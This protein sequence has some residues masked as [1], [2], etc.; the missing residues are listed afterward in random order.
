MQ[1]FHSLTDC[2]L[3]SSWVSI[4]SFDGVHLGHQALIK[5]LVL[6]AQENHSSATII[7]FYPHPAVILRKQETP[8]YLT[9]PD[10]RALLLAKFDVE[11]VITLP[12]DNNMAS[13]SA[14]EFIQ[15]LSK[16][17]N[18][19]K[20]LVGSDFALGKNRLGNVNFLREIG[21]KLGFQVEIIPPILVNNEKVSSS[22]IRSLLTQGEIDHASQM[23]G[24][25]YSIRGSVAHGD[26]RGKKLGIPTANL[27]IWSEQ[28]IPAWG[29]Y[30]TWVRLG[31]Q[32]YPAATN[33][34]VRP[35]FKTNNPVPLIEAHIIDFNENIY[36]AEL[37][38][39]FV[40]RLRPEQHFVSPEAL[41]K[42]MQIDIQDT[43]E[44]LS[45]AV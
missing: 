23:L 20:I 12:F 5:K 17:I 21:N 22:K 7:T 25:N 13:L 15:T 19:K 14:T 27:N 24:R 28:L 44:V 30:A 41:V 36:S 1:H 8:F 29:I 33:I 3:E 2:K 18:Q 43:R 42:Q 9:S 35:T 38:L 11:Y 10:E 4:G 6:G 16:Q 45:H 32:K 26:G 34:G 37:E 31:N 39:E 40:K